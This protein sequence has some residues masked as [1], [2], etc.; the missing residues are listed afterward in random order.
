MILHQRPISF[1]LWL[2]ASLVM[3]TQGWAANEL[4]TQYTQQNSQC[5]GTVTDEQGEPVIGAT[6]LVK[7]TNMISTDILL[8]RM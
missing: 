6:I 3:P 8:C 1:A 4:S 5:T 2:G 7:G